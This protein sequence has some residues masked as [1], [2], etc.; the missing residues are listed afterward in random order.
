VAIDFWNEEE[1]EEE[2][3]ELIKNNVN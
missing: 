2:T 3:N 1:E